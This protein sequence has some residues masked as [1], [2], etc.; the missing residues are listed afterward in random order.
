MRFSIG[1]RLFASVLLAMLAVAVAGILLMRQN[2]M[3]SF[4]EY[5]VNIELDR[6][7]GLSNDLARRYREHGSWNF[8]AAGGAEPAAWIVNEMRRLQ[9]RA[10]M[11]PPAASSSVTR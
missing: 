8:I 1:H 10:S 3:N 7:Q 6:L 9:R 5:A 4:G 2:V 11:A